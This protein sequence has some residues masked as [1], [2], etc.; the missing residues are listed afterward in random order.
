MRDAIGQAEQ[1]ALSEEGFHAGESAAASRLATSVAGQRLR[2]QQTVGVD[3]C[4]SADLLA[5]HGAAPVT[6]ARD[7]S[8]GLGDLI[9]RRYSTSGTRRQHFQAAHE[10]QAVWPRRAPAVP[11]R[12][13]Y[14][15]ELIGTRS[16]PIPLPGPGL[17]L[18]H[19]VVLNAVSWPVQPVPLA[20][21]H[22]PLGW[23]M[24]AK[25]TGRSASVDL[26]RRWQGLGRRQGGR[27]SV[28]WWAVTSPIWMASPPE[29]HSAL[30][31]AGPERGVV[32]GRECAPRWCPAP[33]TW[34]PGNA[35]EAGNET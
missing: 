6:S 5:R 35:G 34:S 15:D 4:G 33:G 26:T 17:V 21:G 10:R 29:V 7:V 3:R 12:Q 2:R 25:P 28:S 23:S 8:L 18:R 20:S 22:G 27:R 30:P 13:A 24:L 31:S 19:S 32:C 14:D 1:D 16:K 9:R 11:L